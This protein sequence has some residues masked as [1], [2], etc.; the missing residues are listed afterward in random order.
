MDG[1][2]ADYIK[3]GAI[4]FVAILVMIY[5]IDQFTPSFSVSL[6]PVIWLILMGIAGYVALRFMKLEKDMDWSK[7]VVFAGILVGVIWLL[8]K[9]PNIAPSFSTVTIQTR[10][11]AMSIVGMGG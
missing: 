3:I 6:G 11:I 8:I 2:T 5:L 4:S 10:S 7:G 9:Y 1:K